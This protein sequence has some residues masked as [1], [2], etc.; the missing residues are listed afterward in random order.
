MCY[1]RVRVINL[2]PF[3]IYVIENVIYVSVNFELRPIRP[4]VNLSPQTRSECTFLH[5]L[6][7]SAHKSPQTGSRGAHL[8]FP[9]G[10]LTLKKNKKKVGGL[11][12]DGTDGSASL[13]LAHL[14]VSMRCDV[15]CH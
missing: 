13:T 3:I 12:S 5:S 9:C 2:V 6:V 4:L 8:I 14:Q 11:D 10:R 1:L 7:G 15:R